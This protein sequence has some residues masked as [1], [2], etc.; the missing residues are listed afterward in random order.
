M[1]KYE[2]DINSEAVQNFIETQGLELKK[3]HAL[4]GPIHETVAFNAELHKDGKAI[5]FA[6]DDGNG[7]GVYLNTHPNPSTKPEIVEIATALEEAAIVWYE[8]DYGDKRP[9]HWKLNDLV[10]EMAMD[11]LEEKEWKTKTRTKIF[12]RAS[13]CGEGEYHVYQRKA[14]VSD[15]ITNAMREKSIVEMVCKRFGIDGVV[16]IRGLRTTEDWRTLATK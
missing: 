13:D 12:V 11:I 16:E 7:G 3:F 8:C 14:K 10:G 15:K 4:G 1:S 2:N 5:A 6:N 9:V